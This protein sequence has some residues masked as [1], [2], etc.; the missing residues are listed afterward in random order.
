MAENAE[1][2][3][4]GQQ[5]LYPPPPEFYRLYRDDADGTAERPLPPLPPQ[6]A[7]ADYQMFGEMQTVRQSAC[8]CPCTRLA[9]SYR[10]AMH[11]LS[12]AYRCC[13]LSHSILY[14]QMEP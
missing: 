2:L 4:S 10:L 7:E 14:T 3:A 13:K 8:R 5:S 11:R 1:H 12:L 6:P 9:G